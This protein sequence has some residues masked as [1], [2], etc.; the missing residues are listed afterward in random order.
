MDLQMRM[1]GEVVSET[2]RSRLREDVSH[3]VSAKCPGCGDEQLV[4][5]HRVISI[6]TENLPTNPKASK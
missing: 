3:T 1:S 6:S 4:Y 2:D 5:A